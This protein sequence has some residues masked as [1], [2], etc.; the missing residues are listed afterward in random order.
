MAVWLENHFLLPD[1]TLHE[2][3]R[4]LLRCP[5]CGSPR[6][7]HKCVPECCNRH[8]CLD[9]HSHLEATVELVLAGT[10]ARTRTR[11]RFG[12]LSYSRVRDDE[13][14]TR[15]GLVRSWRQCHKH[16]EEGL[17]LAMLQRAGRHSVV[18][19]S[20]A[21]RSDDNVVNAASC[22]GCGA[23]VRVVLTRVAESMR[24]AG[25]MCGTTDGTSRTM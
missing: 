21:L 4:F 13:V 5:S 15:T 18:C 14:L 2:Q 7:D 12:L 16:P 20:E 22:T 25:S 1:S 9:C 24:L 3:P 11:G 10:R 6:V 17:E 8:R 19:G 23:D